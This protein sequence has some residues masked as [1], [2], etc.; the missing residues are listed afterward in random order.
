MVGTQ[1]LYPII[2]YVNQ[3]MNS[4]GSTNVLKPLAV[5]ASIVILLTVSLA[6][7]FADSA[8]SPSLAPTNLNAMPVSGNQIALTWNPPVN[9]TQ[10]GVIG[11]QIQRNGTILVNNT[12]STLTNYNDTSLPPGYVGQYQVAA[13][14]AAGIGL[15][16]NYASAA[17]VLYPSPTTQ[18]PTPTDTTSPIYYG[19]NL[20]NYVIIQHRSHH[21]F[22]IDNQTLPHFDRTHIGQFMYGKY[23][24]TSI[25]QQNGTFYQTNKPSPT[26]SNIQD[27]WNKQMEQFKLSLTQDEQQSKNLHNGSQS[28]SNHAFTG[29]GGNTQVT[30]SID[31]HVFSDWIQ[32]NNLHDG[33]QSW[34]SHVLTHAGDHTQATQSIDRYLHSSWIQSKNP[35]TNGVS[36]SGVTHGNGV[37]WHK[38]SPTDWKKMTQN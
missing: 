24:S 28:W 20:T 25:D 7:A 23:N 35:G 17:T 2:T 13:W 3:E 27:K 8:S 36:F 11:Y 12:E 29:A 26:V 19:S 6:P 1:I 30:H 10:S 34:S 5:M 22:Q 21:E 32:S 38:I 14:N 4:V 31:R 15:F 16:S 33:T 9:A 37:G 18:G